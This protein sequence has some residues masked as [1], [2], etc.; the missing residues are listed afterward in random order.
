M[1]TSVELMQMLFVEWQVF[2]QLSASLLVLD[3]VED[4]IV[5]AGIT[6]SSKYII[7]LF[8]NSTNR[9]NLVG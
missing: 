7:T 3:M 2:Q 8:L 9:S 6:S 1:I 5:L 4:I